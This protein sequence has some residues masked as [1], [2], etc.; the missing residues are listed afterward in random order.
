MSEAQARETDIEQIMAEIRDRVKAAG[1]GAYDPSFEEIP[2]KNQAEFSEEETAGALRDRVSE[3]LGDCSV[4]WVYPLPAGNRAVRAYKRVATK[5]AR[6]AVAPLAQRVTE[7]NRSIR[8]GMEFLASAGDR[9]Q[10]EI[11]ELKEQVAALEAR[12]AELAGE[13]RKENEA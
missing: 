4:P 12:L 7:T 11:A 5:M 9:Q 3:R 6:C 8:S 13:K 2:L 1:E 10:Q